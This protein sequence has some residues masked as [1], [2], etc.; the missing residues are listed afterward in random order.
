[1]KLLIDEKGRKHLVEGGKVHTDLGVVDV[2][3]TESNA[4]KSHLGKTFYILNPRIVDIYEKMQRAGSFMLKKDIGLILAYTGVGSG[5]VVVDAGAGSGALAIF[6]ANI[7]KPNGRV[8]TYEIRGNFAEIARKNIAKAG[9]QN[10]VEVKVKNIAEGIDEKADVITLDMA[11]PWKVSKHAHSAL[12][13]GGFI[14]V[15]SP[16]VES[17]KIAAESL[18]EEGF[19]NIKTVEVI[20]REIE[21]RKQGTRPSTRGVGHTAYLTFARKIT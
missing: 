3:E 7:V 8:Y 10:F 6:L 9:L 12:K 16:Y 11:E 13:N 15:Y 1:M 4:V 14:A 21:F 19:K 17:A 18:R 2:D 20:E 5:D